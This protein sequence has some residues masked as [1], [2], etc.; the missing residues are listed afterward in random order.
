[1]NVIALRNMEVRGEGVSFRS[2]EI[3]LWKLLA[4]ANETVMMI[5]KE[6]IEGYDWRG[7]SLKKGINQYRD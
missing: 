3:S 4:D 6:L 1:M 7:V 2:V 5:K